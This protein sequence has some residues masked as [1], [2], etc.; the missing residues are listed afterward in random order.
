MN[1]PFHLW[2]RDKIAE[3]GFTQ[4]EFS[5]L[6]NI[7]ESNVSNYILGKRIPNTRTLIRIIL[8]LHDNGPKE[9]LVELLWEALTSIE[10]IEVY[11]AIE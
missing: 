11:N 4:R 1:K 5:K 7:D 6:V 2:L 8:V 9:V 3:Q 10:N